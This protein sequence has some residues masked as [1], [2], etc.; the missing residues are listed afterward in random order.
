M[1]SGLGKK[2]ELGEL[3]ALFAKGYNLLFTKKTPDLA[4]VRVDPD[5][6]KF[7]ECAVELKAEFIITGDKALE[8]VGEYIGIK[9]LLPHEF[10]DL[11]K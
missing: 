10:L 1:S 11:V 4:V 5:D 9:I 2:E 7:I 6:D 8:D 3:M